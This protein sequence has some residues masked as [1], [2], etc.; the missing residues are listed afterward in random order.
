[1]NPIIVSLS[2]AVIAL[3]VFLVFKAFDRRLGLAF[4][5]LFAVYIALDDLVTG[6]PSAFPAFRLVQAEWNWSGKIYS[7][8]LAVA[9]LLALRIKP[10]AAGITFEQKNLGASLLALVLFIIWGLSLGLLF[11]P[12][13]PSLETIAFQGFMPGLAEETV[14]RGIAPAILLGLIRGKG[15]PEGIPWTVVFITAFMFGVWH[16]LGYSNAGFSFDAMSALFPFI[17]SIAGG[18]LR[19]NSGSLLFPILVHG[20]ANIAFHL[21]PWIRS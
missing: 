7:L 14:Y 11:G 15:Q 4:G 18:W 8:A 2:L 12:P 10:S 6:V 9:V 16:G 3:L 21:S 17:G 13:P 5:I 20:V 19:F 1:M